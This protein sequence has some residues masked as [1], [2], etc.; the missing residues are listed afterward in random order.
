[1]PGSDPV[2]RLIAD[3]LLTRNEQGALRTTRRWQA[4]LA[5]AALQL[6]YLGTDEDDGADLRVPVAYAL[7]DIYGREMPDEQ[8]AQLVTVMVKVEARAI[9]PRHSEYSSGDNPSR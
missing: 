3:G 9:D 4:A 7:V 1:M 5:R 2:D 8:L 6:L